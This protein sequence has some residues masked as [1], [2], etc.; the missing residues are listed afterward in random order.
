MEDVAAR[1]E[2]GEKL[3]SSPLSQGLLLFLLFLIPPPVS[4]RVSPIIY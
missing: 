2:P 3:L 1:V 4:S